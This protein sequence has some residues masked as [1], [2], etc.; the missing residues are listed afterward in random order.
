M[1]VPAAAGLLLLEDMPRLHIDSEG[2]DHGQVQPTV[3]RTVNSSSRKSQQ[4]H[5]GEFRVDEWRGLKKDQCV[6]IPQSWESAE[7]LGIH[8]II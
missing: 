6:Y 2:L 4:L 3:F 1:S 8:H 5:G 7:R